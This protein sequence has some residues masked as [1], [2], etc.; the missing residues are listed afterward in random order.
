MMK[1]GKSISI[2]LLVLLL[3][4]AI[5]LVGC[6]DKPTIKIKSASPATIAVG[7]EYTLDYEASEGATVSVASSEGGTYND[8][9]YKFTASKA[10][11]YTLTVTASLGGNNK[12]SAT[13]TI[14]V[15]EILKTEL[16]AAI[17]KANGLVKGDYSNW[18]TL[19][20]PLAAATAAKNNAA[21]MQADVDAATVA[22]NAAINA[23]SPK[24]IVKADVTAASFTFKGN[25][26]NAEGYNN[27]TAVVVKVTEL[28]ADTTVKL[29]SEY[30]KKMKDIIATLVERLALNVLD[31]GKIAVTSLNNVKIAASS[32]AGAT[33]VFKDSNGAVVESPDG[34]VTLASVTEGTDYKFTVRAEKGELYAEKVVNYTFEKFGFKS[35]NDK[36]LVDASGNV[37][38]S[39]YLEW[40]ANDMRK[41]TSGVNLSGN[42]ELRFD[43]TLNDIMD[44][45]FAALGI[46]FDNVA[47]YEVTKGEFAIRYSYSES[48][49]KGLKIGGGA[50][51]NSGADELLVKGKTIT[52]VI[53]R[54]TE[55][56]GVNSEMYIANSGEK[57]CYSSA[58]THTDNVKF[59]FNFEH[60]KATVSNI[61]ISANAAE[62]ANKSELGALIS[63]NVVASDYTTATYAN[64][65][66]AL[67][68][69]ITVNNEFSTAAQIKTA[70]D[71][72][73]TTYASLEALPVVKAT[74]DSATAFTYKKQTYESNGYT[75]E[76]FKIVYD[77][78]KVINANA[79]DYKLQS[80]YNSRVDA[81]IVKLVSVTPVIIGI[82]DGSN[83]LVTG[84]ITLRATLQGDLVEADWSIN[85]GAAVTATEFKFKPTAGNYKIKVTTVNG[86]S[87]TVNTTV[88]ETTLSANNEDGSP[89]RNGHDIITDNDKGTVTS[90]NNMEWGWNGDINKAWLNAEIAGEYEI[91]ADITYN[92]RWRDASVVTFHTAA[93]VG[94]GEGDVNDNQSVA[95]AAMCYHTGNIEVGARNAVGGADGKKN[96]GTDG[97]RALMKN[98]ST[99]RYVFGRTK[100]VAG[101]EYS[102]SYYTK[103]IDNTG[104]LIHKVEIGQETINDTNRRFE[105]VRPGFNFER[106]A[107]EI[108]NIMIIADEIVLKDELIAVV[109]AASALVDTDYTDFAATQIAYADAMKAVNGIGLFDQNAIAA[110]ITALKNASKALVKVAVTDKADVTDAQIRYGEATYVAADYNNFEAVKAEIV[111]LNANTSLTQSQYNTKV[112][113]QI[114][115]LEGFTAMDISLLNNN[116]F[117]SLNGKTNLNLT[118][119]TLPQGSTIAWT[120]DGVPAGT[121]ENLICTVNPGDRKV[122]AATVTGDSTVTTTVTFAGNQTYKLTDGMFSR[123]ISVGDGSVFNAYEQYSWG[124]AGDQKV[125]GNTIISGNAVVDFDLNVYDPDSDATEVFAAFFAKADQNISGLASHGGAGYAALRFSADG[126]TIGG[127]EVGLGGINPKRENNESFDISKPGK[128]NARLTRTISGA[129]EKIKIEL[130]DNSGA[131]V[132]SLEGDTGSYIG[133]V[134][135]AFNLENIKMSV[136]NVVV[137][138][139]LET[140]SYDLI[141]NAIS[142]A[143]DLNDDA[144][145]TETWKA[146]NDAINAANDVVLDVSNLTVDKANKAIADVEAAKAALVASPVNVNVAIDGASSKTYQ[147]AYSFA[148]NSYIL[149]TSLEDGQS[150]S[151]TVNGLNVESM[152]G[153]YTHAPTG[154][155]DQIMVTVSNDEGVISSNKII[156]R[157]NTAMIHHDDDRTWDNYFNIDNNTRIDVVRADGLDWNK[158]DRVKVR[159]GGV[160]EGNI[161][162]TFKTRLTGRFNAN[163]FALMICDNNWGDF[164]EGRLGLKYKTATEKGLLFRDHGE[165]K[166]LANSV[167][168][169]ELIE[170]KVEVRT[171]VCDEDAAKKDTTFKISIVGTDIAV[172]SKVHDRAN[173]WQVGLQFEQLYM[174]V[175]DMDISSVN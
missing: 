24:K 72:L 164:D 136:D 112:N 95:Y 134:R 149:T 75:S 80:L 81:E 33:I 76:S 60:I 163:I 68:S 157:K 34:V 10:G 106:I 104:K 130:L 55:V 160:Y 23:L 126:L 100:V 144:Y 5:C 9:T 133:K 65:K 128:Y 2:L 18:S 172:Q 27:I 28:N 169:G 143:D 105:R 57:L 168:V 69:A 45:T 175:F 138:T 113:E 123:G 30:D 85:D 47:P 124:S 7:G 110:K 159:Y 1:K 49:E 48:R 44:D 122:V 46:I 154:K 66:V 17:T 3:S 79:T 170:F 96:E 39:E 90:V 32:E 83:M 88:Q 152:G 99:L 125:I 36:V 58:M 107:C 116:K 115:I 42:F 51:T 16:D 141:Y 50:G 111:A 54:F 41:A 173:P 129:E 165:E 19:A 158:A 148:P 93:T 21:L 174:R 156:I 29:I 62:M 4:M 91:S 15:V 26:Y 118:A 151:Y 38:C 166:E 120:V 167:K 43:V 142:E 25:E 140:M 86:A 153:V 171:V 74:E 162:V 82:E 108:S 94:F 87:A 77:E 102:Y 53:R 6:A 73:K 63:K 71:S 114:A 92:N 67:T 150:A 146:Y 59:A 14:N 109:G 31:S 56:D 161:D 40:G 97:T 12:S 52:V 101:E 103:L 13:A 84:E 121:K 131:V 35:L 61:Y 20:E 135:L 137:Y 155:T 37:N 98:A 145:T 8:E 119:G 89:N 78:I 11:T 147:Y 117:V 127:L 22:L 64:Y 70:V 132:E 139:D